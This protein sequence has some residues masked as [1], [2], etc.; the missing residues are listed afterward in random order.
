MPQVANL[1]F[2]ANFVWLKVARRLPNRVP[3]FD[4][5]VPGTPTAL[6]RVLVSNPCRVSARCI[7]ASALPF[8]GWLLYDY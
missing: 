4:V 8:L 7:A 5:W 2:C 1:E 3:L 6:R